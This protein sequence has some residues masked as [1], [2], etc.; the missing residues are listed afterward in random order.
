MSGSIATGLQVRIWL[1]LAAAFILFLV[2]F[3]GILLPFVAG[4]ALGY[5]LDPLADRLERWRVPRGVAAMLLL[6]AFL[7]LM[8][9]VLLLMLPLLQAQVA[10]LVAKMPDY[11]ARAQAGALRVANLMETSLAPEDLAKLRESVTGYAGTALGW[12]GGLL[13]GLVGGG[14]AFFNLMALLFVTPVVAF[15]MLRDWDT[16]VAAIDRLLPRRHAATIRAQ[17]RRVDDTLAGFLRGQATVCILLGAFYAIGLT[18]AGLDFGFTVGL[19][20]GLVSFIPYVGSI[21][22][23]VASVGLALIQFDS[24]VGVAV[25]AAIFVAG[26]AIEGNI[27]TPILVGDRVGLHPVWVIFALFAGAALLGFLGMLIALPVAA[28]IGV[29]VRF[30]IE[31]YMASPLYDDGATAIPLSDEAAPVG[32]PTVEDGR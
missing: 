21:F 19:V 20:S 17:A 25:V 18:L 26:Q 12:L 14:L 28:V 27:L 31:R 1:A 9:G 4:L 3:Q 8:V 7:M 23:L 15:Y 10:D 13:Q 6:I 24:W 22:G 29:L 32:G 2:V 30:A 5:F 11:V 16:F